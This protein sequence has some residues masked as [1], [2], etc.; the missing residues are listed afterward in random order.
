[1]KIIIAGSRGFSDYDLLRAK[2]DY[3]FSNTSDIE[4]VCGG[5]RGADLLGKQYAQECGYGIKMFIPDWDGLGKRAGMVRNAQMGDYADAL[6]AFWNGKSRG[7]KHMIEYAK[8]KG[9]KIR[10]QMF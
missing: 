4:I 10:I 8:T 2:C 3:W 9:L 6:V 5:T 1:M 7:T